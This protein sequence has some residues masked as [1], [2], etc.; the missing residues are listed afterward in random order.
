VLVLGAIVLLAV[1]VALALFPSWRASNARLVA[2]ADND[3]S[4]RRSSVAAGAAA[5]AGAP[6]PM[7]IGIRHA[8]E[9]GR[10]RGAVP[11]AAALFGTTAAVAALVG[12]AVFGGSLTNLLGTPRLYGQTWQ[13][14]LSN[15][16]GAQASTL[17]ESIAANPAVTHVTYGISG[18]LIDVNRVPVNVIMTRTAKGPPLFGIVAGH[19][20]TGVG[21]I[22]LGTQTLDAAHAQVG[23]TVT[24]S[25]IGPT[26]KT[27]TGP[28]RVVGE[29]AFPPVI[30][31]GGLGDGATMAIP[32]VLH[33]ACGVGPTSD[34]CRSALNA[35]IMNPQQTDWGMSVAVAPTPQGRALLA[36]L[37]RRLSTDVDVITRPI[38]LVNFGASVNFPQLL[39]LTLAV[40]G[41]ATLLHLLLV[42][43]ARRRR[44]LAL[45]KVLG[46][47]R[48]Q[49]RATVCWQALTVGI[50]GL[51]VGLPVGVAIGHIAWNA[52]VHNVGAVP[53]SVVPV[54]PLVVIGAAV[55]GVGL[56]LALLPSTIASRV[57]PAVAL[58]EQ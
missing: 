42:S 28:L 30:S 18:K 5:R 33:F 6:A 19:E 55:V 16:T 36:T 13:L 49:V 39:G 3:V 4:A 12:A 46:F 57:R 24:M 17:A 27:F 48:V 38:D 54:A 40:F 9:R 22:A 25:L 7:V 41:I 26:G 47:V 34:R 50:V 11:V 1:V 23:S 20:A 14:D 58:R 32:A 10:G 21:E 44:E 37:E 45:L 15:L 8:L 56:L 53:S 29:L 31:A 52:F 51:V 35:R 43:V 2:V